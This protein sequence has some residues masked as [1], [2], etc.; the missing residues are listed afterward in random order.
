MP[1]VAPEIDAMLLDLPTELIE[2]VLHHSDTPTFLE[3][4]FSCRTLYE[5][6]SSCRE[7]IVHHLRHTPGLNSDTQ[8]LQ[9]RQLFWVLVDRAHKQL[10]GAQFRACCTKFQ[11]NA[12]TFDA[13]ASSFAPKDQVLAL[14][15]R[16]HAGVHIFQAENGDLRH[17]AQ[18]NLA[19]SQ[20]GKSQVLRTA[21]DSDDGVFVLYSFTPAAAESDFETEHPF[22]RQ[23]LQS[24]A[25][26]GQI[27][28]AR[29][30]FRAPHDPVR[31][32]AFPDQKDY[33][34]LALSAA[35][36]DTFAISWQHVR[37]HSDYEVIL[38]NALTESRNDGLS[39]I[40]GSF[41]LVSY[42][43]L[44]FISHP[45]PFLF[46]RSLIILSRVFCIHP[47]VFFLAGFA[48]VV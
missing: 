22:V 9:S 12:D 16:G 2:L 36:R 37:E 29:H 28:L 5:I 30:S 26:G 8:S 45:S 14:V 41:V 1:S 24:R 17:K 21:F 46:P 4:A 6:A 38:Y 11:T 35:H 18:L 20:P 34:P 48:S 7:V 32:C 19:L 13:K 40:I 10:Y 31:V 15:L 43:Q 33:R 42:L 27:Y 47:L 3:A 44:D 39:G 25:S 23:A